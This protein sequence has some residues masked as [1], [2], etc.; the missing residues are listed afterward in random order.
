[1][2]LACRHTPPPSTPASSAVALHSIKA[3]YFPSQIWSFQANVLVKFYSYSTI[4]LKSLPKGVIKEQCKENY[5]KGLLK[6]KKTWKEYLYA[7]KYSKKILRGPSDK[8][9]R[10]N[11]SN[12]KFPRRSCPP[13]FLT[14]L[15]VLVSATTEVNM[16]TSLN[17]EG[18]TFSQFEWILLRSAYTELVWWQQ[19]G[20]STGFMQWR[21]LRQ[22]KGGANLKKNPV[23]SN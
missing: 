4:S 9:K 7:L 15:I 10:L 19:F 11:S 2:L 20:T 6:R 17:N 23:N 18:A 22:I 8:N 1:V 3:L 13:S 21:S 5:E 14:S 16:F 12:H